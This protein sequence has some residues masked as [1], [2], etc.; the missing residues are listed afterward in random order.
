MP[1]KLVYGGSALGYHEG[2]P[3][4]VSGALPGERVEVE[5]LR[6]AKGVMHG[7]LLEVLAPSVERVKPLCPY[8]GRCGGC[9]YQHLEP[10]RQL[11]VKREILRETLRRIGHIQWSDEIITHAAGSWHYRNQV[12]LKVR[13][14][15]N[16]E[17]A[18]GF[19]EA[20][21]WHLVPIDA[22]LISSPRLNELIREL[23]RPEWSERLAR[24]RTVELRADDRDQEVMMVLTGG[25]C[26][27]SEPLAQDC[28][29]RLAGVVS[30]AIGPESD[31]RV[32]EGVAAQPRPRGPRAGSQAA[33]VYGNPQLAYTVGR[34]RYE[35]SPRSFF[36]SSRFLL[37]ELVDTVMGAAQESVTLGGGLALDLYAGAGLFTLPLAEGFETV[38][39]VEENPTAAADLARNAS[40][41]RLGN[42]HITAAPAAEFLRRYAQARPELVVL[43]PPR[44]GAEAGV[45]R[46]VAELGPRRVH[47]VSCNPPTL[48][49]DLS[50]LLGNG[51]ELSSLELFDLFPQTFH[52]ETVVKLTRTGL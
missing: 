52:L 17:T 32:E 1:H 21:S 39:A 29:S 43:D 19:F 6:Q 7:R 5:P 31:S 49:R 51:Y 10:S 38:M 15:P 26:D 50:Y 28:L 48:A 22:C 47:Y 35:I 37:P 18:I 24:Y 4:L 30:V 41:N 3:V 12:Q 8:F 9:H 34:F 13:R 11:E 16:S 23:N 40:V 33:K 20:E 44:V 46:S 2:Q 45:L 42:I 27:E 14:D 36:Q 25:T